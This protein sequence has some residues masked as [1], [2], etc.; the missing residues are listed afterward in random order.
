MDPYRFGITHHGFGPFPHGLGVIE[1][2]QLPQFLERRRA[3]G[4]SDDENWEAA[5]A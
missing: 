4:D 5:E 1:P 2:D 3:T